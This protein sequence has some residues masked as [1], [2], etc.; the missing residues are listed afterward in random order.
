MTK[1]YD[2]AYFERWY[3]N[4]QTRVNT[5]AEVRR[6]AALAV[7]MSEY[8]LRR[9]LKSV[10]DVGCGEGAWLGHLR[11]FRPKIAYAGL[12][13]SEYV[14]GRFGR[15]R[16]IHRATFGELA[17]LRLPPFDLVVC[18]DVLHYVEEDEI[19]AGVAELARICEGIAYIE[20]L[21]AEDDII[22]DL[23]GL[24]RRPAAWYRGVMK[25]AGF[26]Q[27]GPYTWASPALRGM[28]AELETP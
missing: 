6:K 18:S 12:D 3:R 11:A 15:S 19:R 20:V 24:I 28:L 4:R 1:Q 8:F 9:Q 10:L 25:K 17:A 14:V 7:A 5:P 16:N 23:N 22:G 21:T 27:V 13:S 26:A 2:R